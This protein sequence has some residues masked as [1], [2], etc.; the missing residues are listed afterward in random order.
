VEP[1]VPLENIRVTTSAIRHPVSRLGLVNNVRLEGSNSRL[2][3]TDVRQEFAT[4]QRPN[5]ASMNRESA[6][7]AVDVAV[8][9]CS[10][11]LVDRVSVMLIMIDSSSGAAATSLMHISFGLV[12]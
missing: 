1:T 9:S 7:I 12:H 11:L 5:R 6:V 10:V 4:G 2:H 3:V 8:T